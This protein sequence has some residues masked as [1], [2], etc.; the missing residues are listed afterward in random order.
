MNMDHS[1]LNHIMAGAANGR[2]T[3][4]AVSIA[5]INW[6]SPQLLENCLNAIFPVPGQLE[7][8]AVAVN[9]GEVDADIERRRRRFPSVQFIEKARPRGVAA[10]RNLAMKATSGDFVLLLDAMHRS[11]RMRLPS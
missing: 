1:Q 8:E 3:A 9:Y 10:A 5:I 7:F 11:R 4:P 6:G 2:H